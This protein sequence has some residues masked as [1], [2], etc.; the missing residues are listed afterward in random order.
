MRVDFL[1]KERF[2][3]FW[4]RMRYIYPISP[5]FLSS[6][7]RRAP[8]FSPSFTVALPSLC[9]FLLIGPQGVDVLVEHLRQR[10]EC[11]HIFVIDL[12]LSR[13]RYAVYT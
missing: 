6:F 4:A 7:L 9:P 3:G 13:D 5:S 10:I 11:G 12:A 8:S 1:C 2:S